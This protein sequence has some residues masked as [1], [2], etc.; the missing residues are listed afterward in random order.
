MISIPIR[1][2][3]AVTAGLVATLLWSVSAAAVAG[4]GDRAASRQAAPALRVTGAGDVTTL[5][6]RDLPLGGPSLR[7]YRSVA[8]DGS[9]AFSDQAR[10]GAKE[11]QVRTFVSASDAPAM[12]TAR[13]QQRYWHEQAQAFEQRLEQREWAVRFERAARQRPFPSPEYLVSR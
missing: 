13:R 11:V 2:R 3:E 7:I 1:G 4:Q 10:P 5:A 9:V 12:A 8:A 6:A